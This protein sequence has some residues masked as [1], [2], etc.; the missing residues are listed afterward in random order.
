MVG[1][2]T[3]SEGSI[4]VLLV[5]DDEEDAFLTRDVLNEIPGK[6]FIMDWQSEYVT[7]LESICAGN[8]DVY[9]IDYRLGSRTGLELIRE[10]DKRVCHAPMILLT[11]QGQREIVFEAMQAGAADYLEKGNLNPTTLERAIRYSLQNKASELELERRVQERTV[12]LAEAN[13]LLQSEITVRKQAEEALRQADR[14][15]DEFL[16]TL[17]HELRNPLAPIR[18][19]IEIMRLGKAVPQAVDRGREI[20]ERQVAHMVRLIDDLLDISRIT[21]GK[22]ELR[23]AAVEL[24]SIIDGAIEGSKPLVAIGKH[25]LVVDVPNEPIVIEADF[26]RLTQVLINL[27]NNAAKYSDPEKTIRLI[28]AAD[29]REVVFRVIDEGVGI[30]AE[31]LPQVFEMFS[32]SERLKDRSQGGLG[33]GLSLVNVL[34]ELH[35]GNVTAASE[36]VGKGSEFTVRLPRIKT[37]G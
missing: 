28:A 3:A 5:D 4:R 13:H 20:M 26:T 27:I 7:A 25:H 10:A 14:R 2:A 24:N 8:H 37:G 21:R 22:I 9:L 34:V 16:A 31:A 1:P 17:A 12:E 23:L 33:I 36:G 11:G 35:G 30:D 19:A 6:P 32:Q 29:E 15:K 18:N